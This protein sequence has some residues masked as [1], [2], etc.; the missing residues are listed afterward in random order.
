MKKTKTKRKNGVGLMIS[1]STLHFVVVI[2]RK[3]IAIVNVSKT[4]KGYGNLL[5]P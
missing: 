2:D 5:F 1:S 3:K 4:K